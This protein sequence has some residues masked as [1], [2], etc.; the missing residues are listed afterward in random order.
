MSKETVVCPNEVHATLERV[1]NPKDEL[2]FAVVSYSNV[3]TLTVIGTGT[4]G[5][6]AA[7][8]YMPDTQESYALICYTHKI[9]MATTRK[10]AY[11]AYVPDTLNPMRKS[12]LTTHKPQVRNLLKPQH[13]QLEVTDRDELDESVI[14]SKIGFASG[15]ANY[16]ISEEKA[17]AIRAKTGSGS[18]Y[19]GSAGFSAAPRAGSKGFS[20]AP[21]SSG[22]NITIGADVREGIANVRSNGHAATWIISG[23]DN[24]ASGSTLVMCA[25]GTGDV[26]E[27]ASALDRSRVQYALFRVLETFDSKTSNVKFGFVKMIPQSVPARRRGIVG[28]HSGSVEKAFSN[29]HVHF[30]IDEPSQISHAEAMEKIQ[31]LSGSKSAV[32]NKAE[33]KLKRGEQKWKAR[34]DLLPQSAKNSG[35]KLSFA[36]EASLRGAIAA[37]H[38]DHD[39]TNWALGTLE[40]RSLS[41]IGAGTGDVSE[42]L[43]H[44]ND[45]IN[46]GVLRVTEQIDK[47]TT[48]KF[49][50]FYFQPKTISPMLRA[51]AGTIRSDIA[52]LFKPW[53]VDFFVEDPSEISQS[54]VEDKV[55]AASG[56][57]SNVTSRKVT[58]NK[59]A[60][61]S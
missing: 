40:N 45:S 2:T 30:T 4:G 61:H 21:M 25:S 50:F 31:S 34:K 17:S 54:V 51:R 43:A 38:S 20:R 9:E 33:S 37:V 36:D 5:L 44:L 29:Y 52:D 35:Q 1:R 53:H 6:E 7:K 13:V 39:A 27:L 56:T 41:L 23:Y 11:V 19:R 12:L 3:N 48:T 60:G 59:F 55:G 49:V 46:F 28:T 42:M 8:Q 58:S 26:D 24:D 16:E 47:S 18:N 22:S 10:Y 15:T 57:K 14:M 32:T